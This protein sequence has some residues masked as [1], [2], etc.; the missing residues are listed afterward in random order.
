M[1]FIKVKLFLLIFS[2]LSVSAS[3]NYNESGIIRL[4]DVIIEDYYKINQNLM[5]AKNFEEYKKNISIIISTIT[6][7][8]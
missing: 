6:K 8:I 4:D 1:N 2:I 5:Y 3:S 7:D